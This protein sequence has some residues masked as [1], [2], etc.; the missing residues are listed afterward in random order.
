MPR[1]GAPRGPVV[2]TTPDHPE[3]EP[4]S[5]HVAELLHGK[6]EVIKPYH[7]AAWGLQMLAG[8]NLPFETVI[9]SK[10]PEQP[11]PPPLVSAAFSR[12]HRNMP[13]NFKKTIRA[14]H[15]QGGLRAVKLM[16]IVIEKAASQG[17]S[18]YFG[19]ICDK[20]RENILENPTKIA[21]TLPLPARTKALTPIDLVY[22]FEDKKYKQ[23]RDQF[24]SKVVNGKTKVCASKWPSWLYDRELYDPDKI[25]VGLFCGYLLK[26]KSQLIPEVCKLHTSQ[27][28]GEDV[29][30]VVVGIDSK[31][32]NVTILD[33]F[34][35]IMPFD[36]N[37]F[38]ATFLYRIVADEDCTIVVGT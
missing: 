30:D 34:T 4:H 19:S 28:L 2:G 29:S 37:V 13:G 36:I 17:R 12:I 31:N 23:A 22:M 35:N 14:L 15:S 38:H 3:H 27:R 21:V 7:T 5:E 6:L 20:I 9:L 8:L 24:L 26:Y 32:I 25:D 10:L 11:R 18:D 33:A 16:I 1:Q